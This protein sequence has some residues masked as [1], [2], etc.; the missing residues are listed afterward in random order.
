MAFLYRDIRGIDADNL[1]TSDFT[2]VAWLDWLTLI[3]AVKDA[4]LFTKNGFFAGKSLFL[5]TKIER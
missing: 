3:A 4:L 1:H 2:D 5:C